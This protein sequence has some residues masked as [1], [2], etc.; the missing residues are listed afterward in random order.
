[1]PEL[2]EL[3]EEKLEE[4]YLT[5]CLTDTQIARLYNTYQPKI[6]QLRRKYGIRTIIKS[7]RLN[8]PPL[9]EMQKQVLIG[10]LLGDG[11][12]KVVSPVTSHFYESHSMKQEGYLR[13]K[14]SIFADLVSRISTT[15]KTAKGNVYQGYRFATYT[16]RELG[17]YYTLFY[18]RGVKVFPA[19]LPDLMTP[20]VLAVW[21]MDD[22]SCS[23]FHPSITFGLDDLSLKRAVGS[24]RKL[25]LKPTIWED[26]RDRTCSI[27]FPGQSDLFFELVTPH[28]P[29]CMRYKLPSPSERRESDRNAKRLTPEIAQELSKGGM[30]Q[31]QIATL[32][33]VGV[34]TVRR[35][36]HANGPPK[37]MGRPAK[38]KHTTRS[39]TIALENFDSTVWKSLAPDEQDRWVDD[40]FKILRNTPFPYPEQLDQ[41]T[42]HLEYAKLQ[43]LTCDLVVNEIRPATNVG[44][45][46]CYPYF[47][48][49]YDA[50]RIGNI[51]AYESWHREH[52][53]SAAIQFQLKVGDPVVPY[54][55]LRAITMQVRTPTVFRPGVAKYLCDIYGSGGK[56]YDP[57]MGY[58]GRMLGA[59]AAGMFYVGTDVEKTTVVGNQKL[60]A[61]LGLSERVALHNSPAEDFTPQGEFDIVF[62]SP[63][64]FSQE[65]YAGG[66]DQ[67]WR[68]HGATVDA[69]F[70]GF[71]IPLIQRSLHVLKPGGHLILNIANVKQGR[72]HIPLVDLTRTAALQIGFKPECEI[73]MPLGNLNKSAPWEPILVFRV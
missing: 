13:W 54:R 53:L 52:D 50:A 49:R 24:L 38:R 55:V 11:G 42:R 47:P 36:I 20:L 34:S 59:L 12:L 63:P 25:G 28:I 61:D 65:Q 41:D 70:A 30:I 3:T 22:G 39:A 15:Q 23:T 8:L 51:S 62:T 37:Q 60:A 48:N 31:D 16:S 5:D 4:L 71:M 14:V 56:V 17:A 73:R 27:Q 9:T 45:K 40:I 69:W 67:S 26:D 46:L 57:C 44:L 6:S 35:R 1:M 64:Y 43:A 10:S 18:P 2:S 58:G 21:Y 72:K 68:K 19:S 7:D 29:E 32:Y 33:N 66:A